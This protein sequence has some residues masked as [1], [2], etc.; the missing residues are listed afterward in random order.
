MNIREKDIPSNHSNSYIATI[1]QEPSGDVRKFNMFL[2]IV[3]KAIKLSPV[4][5]FQSV[6]QPSKAYSYIN[7]RKDHGYI[8][9]LSFTFLGLYIGLFFAFFLASYELTDI[10]FSLFSF[11]FA[12]AVVGA[13]AV[14][15]TENVAGVKTFTCTVALAAIVSGSG[16]IIGVGTLTGSGTGVI[17]LALT[18][19]GSGAV[20]HAV[21]GQVS[22]SAVSGIYI[23]DIALIFIEAC[24]VAIVG[25]VLVGCI[26]VFFLSINLSPI[27]S[28]I[29]LITASICWLLAFLDYTSNI[30]LPFNRGWLGLFGYLLIFSSCMSIH[31]VKNVQVAILPILYS[32]TYFITSQL[33]FIDQNNK[34]K[35]KYKTKDPMIEDN[36]THQLFSIGQKA[37][38]IWG[39][40]VVLPVLIILFPDEL[41]AIHVIGFCIIPI[42]VLHIPDYLYCI[43]LW[44]YQRLKLMN[45]L[46]RKHNH[47]QFYEK[48]IL[49]KHEMLYFQLPG[50]HKIFVV[51]VKNNAMTIEEAINKIED[52]YCLTFQQKQAQK[53]ILA[54]GKD[55]DLAHAF[56]HYLISQE[57]I[58]LLKALSQKNKLADLYLILFDHLKLTE[59][60]KITNYMRLPISIFSFLN[61]KKHA[62]KVSEN[63]LN[64]LK[65]VSNAMKKE[66]GLQFN[67]EMIKSIEI[68]CNMLSANQLKDFLKQCA[69]L[70]NFPKNIPYFQQLN[71][72][73][74][75]IS[76]IYMRLF[77]INYI[78]QIETKIQVMSNQKQELIKF[79]ESIT[80]ILHS[81]F[82]DIWKLT[83]S[84]F[85][86]LIETEITLVQGQIN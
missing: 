59:K 78:D 10:L 37:S 19:I 1:K 46:K 21:T 56:I 11:T 2:R 62:N 7:K 20:V 68:V 65:Y 9:I 3:Y 77:Q 63:I 70:P 8:Y 44:Y 15:I 50:L 28:L 60:Q 84:H 27:F 26:V 4:L 80:K 39:P 85:S 82:D 40:I 64:K 48:T 54:L 41:T 36:L 75:N 43:F 45:I 29:L 16:L 74:S 58:P 42:I 31:E 73:F 69:T 86:Q 17:T 14:T 67:D 38:F 71:L 13:I 79:S 33:L 83:L 51:A 57:N 61:R 5:F 55:Q 72:V 76:N 6:F 66:K 25:S 53:A 18:G 81:P 32:I 35:I 49:F 34:Y 47:N 52:L 22:R 24:T 12:G 23:L 30:R